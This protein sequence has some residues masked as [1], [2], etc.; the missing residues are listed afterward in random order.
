MES[1]AF[2]EKVKT[3]CGPYYVDPGTSSATGTVVDQGHTPHTVIFPN[4]Y[5]A[6]F[7]EEPTYTE[8][9]TLM[10]TE[11][12]YKWAVGDGSER[13]EYGPIPVGET[14]YAG[15]YHRVPLRTTG[16]DGLRIMANAE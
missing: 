4:A 3:A 7:T 6:L 10:Y 11:V 12:G 1:T 16:V 9:G 2:A 15:S 14:N 13:G 8:E 5:I